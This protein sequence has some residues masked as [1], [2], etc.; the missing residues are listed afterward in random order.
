M[1]A[2]LRG[3]REQTFTALFGAGRGRDFYKDAYREGLEHLT[4][5]I[6][7]DESTVL[8]WPWEALHDPESVPL[9][10]ACRLERQL[11]G[12]HDPLPLPLPKKLPRER[13]NILLITARPYEAG[14]GFRT[15]SRPLL[16]LIGRKHLPA[17]IDMPRPPTFEQ[18]RRRLSECKG[19]YHIVHFDGH[20]GYGPLQNGDGFHGAERL[21]VGDDRRRGGERL[22]LGG[23]VL[24]ARRGAQRGGDGLFAVCQRRGTIHPT[25]LRA[26]VRLGQRHRTMSFSRCSRRWRCTSALSMRIIWN[27]WQRPLKR[28]KTGLRSSGF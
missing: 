7:S 13:I 14:V 18:L 27:T 19:Y 15:L 24:T 20:G 26:A 16:E 17:N 8:A 22:R 3:W 2:A 11:S 4:L 28:R 10:H 5:K 25:V 21:P 9:A 12:Q 6:A 23:G 1:Q